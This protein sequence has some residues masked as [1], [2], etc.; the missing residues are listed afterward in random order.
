MSDFALQSLAECE[1]LVYKLVSIDGNIVL[2]DI[3]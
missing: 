2:I 1:P 3:S